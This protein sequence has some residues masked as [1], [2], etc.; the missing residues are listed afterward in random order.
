MTTRRS[1]RPSQPSRPWSA[2]S[3]QPS[4]RRDPDA[5]LSL[6]DL[7][8]DEPEPAVAEADAVV[9]AAP[10]T[11]PGRRTHHRVLDHA[12][13]QARSAR[14]AP[15]SLVVAHAFVS[16]AETSESERFLTVGGTAEVGIELFEG[17]DYVALGHLHRPQRVRAGDDTIRYPGTPLPYSFSETH[18]KQVLL[19]DMA[20]D[21]WCDVREVEVPLGRRVATVTGTVEELLADPAHA[22]AADCFVRAVV[23]DRGYVVDAKSRLQARFPHVVEIV[24]RPTLGDPTGVEVVDHTVRRALP[25]LAAA[26]G[27]W[28]DVTGEEPE[29]VERSLLE[30]ALAHVA[31]A[32]VGV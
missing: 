30:S 23:T 27:F 11:G 17:F 21:G 2:P 13:G 10:P 19:V 20:A 16:G 4:H 3:L 12:L 18:P 25:P 31:S 6:F 28:R 15:R 29:E 1:R 14:R 32:E 24:P 9:A 5:P 26:I 22:A 7:L 8:V